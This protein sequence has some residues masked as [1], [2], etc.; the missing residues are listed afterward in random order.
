MLPYEVWFHE[1]VSMNDT[2]EINQQDK[3][4]FSV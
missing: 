1:E 2:F 4:F 3:V